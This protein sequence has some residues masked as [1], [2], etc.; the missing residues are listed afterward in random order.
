MDA[1]GEKRRHVRR[2]RQDNRMTSGTPPMLAR[3]ALDRHVQAD[4]H[5]KIVGL[6]FQP[7]TRDLEQALSFATNALLHAMQAVTRLF[8]GEEF[9]RTVKSDIDRWDK[10]GQ[11]LAIRRQA[12]L[13][14][15]E[16]TAGYITQMIARALAKN[17]EEIVITRDGRLVHK[18]PLPT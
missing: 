2:V 18:N 17:D 5:G 1:G 3:N 7:E 4:E 15:F 11:R 9:D 10:L 14:G 12:N 8:R 6:L 13:M 16:T